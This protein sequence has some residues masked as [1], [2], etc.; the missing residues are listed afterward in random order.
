MQF[1][2]ALVVRGVKVIHHERVHHCTVERI[3]HA[4]VVQTQ[5]SF[6]AQIDEKLVDAPVSS[7]FGHG[8]PSGDARSSGVCAAMY[9]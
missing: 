7:D 4:P 1:V 2:G 6:S 9:Y 8:C 3:V 5:E